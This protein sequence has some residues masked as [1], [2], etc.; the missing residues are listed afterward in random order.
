MLF[1]TANLLP[2]ES[3]VCI[4]RK[5]SDPSNDG[6]LR[7]SLPYNER[8]LCQGVVAP[9]HTPSHSCATVNTQHCS[10]DSKRELWFV[11]DSEV[12]PLTRR[13]NWNKGVLDDLLQRSNYCGKF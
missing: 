5:R 4:L 10:N 8:C 11:D 12:G 3:H 1:F 7:W 2:V 13:H 6:V 9:K